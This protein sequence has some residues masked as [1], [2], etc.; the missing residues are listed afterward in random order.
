MITP[1]NFVVDEHAVLLHAELTI[2]ADVGN[3]SMLANR[4]V[5]RIMELLQ[6]GVL[7]DLIDRQAFVGVEHQHFAHQVS[8]AIVGIGEPVSWVSLL[9]C[10]QVLQHRLSHIATNRLD[11]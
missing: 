6:V 8:Y 2:F 3:Y 10:L 1:V 5:G 4:L 11:V 7:Q 9:D